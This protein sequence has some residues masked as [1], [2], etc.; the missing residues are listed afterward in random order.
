MKKILILLALIAFAPMAWA[1][2]TGSGTASDP[3]QIS[4]TTDWNTLAT[5]VNNGSQTYSGTY[6]KLTADITVESQRRKMGRLRG[7]GGQRTHR[8]LQQLPVRSHTNQC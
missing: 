6:F 4:S 7:L 1:Q 5:N 8:H 3:Y 2:W